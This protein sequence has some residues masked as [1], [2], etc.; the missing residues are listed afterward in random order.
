MIKRLPASA[1][2]ARAPFGSI[3]DTDGALRAQAAGLPRQTS[4]VPGRCI[5]SHQGGTTAGTRAGCIRQHHLCEG[6]PAERT[7]RPLRSAPGP[8]AVMGLQAR[9]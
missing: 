3:D 7:S 8:Q 5:A 6:V 2:R 4:A 9:M 1:T